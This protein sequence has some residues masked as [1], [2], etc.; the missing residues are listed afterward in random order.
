MKCS[1]CKSNLFT[2]DIISCC[3]DCDQNGA[4][5]EEAGEY[6]YDYRIIEEKILERNQVS[7][8]G[9]CKFDTAFGPGCYMFR[10]NK[11]GHKTN[12]AMMDGC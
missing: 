7:E 2:I 8:D 11:C 6:V 3:D 4:Y 10:C 12:L 5:D 1:K 9:E